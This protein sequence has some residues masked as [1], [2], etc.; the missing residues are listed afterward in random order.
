MNTKLGIPESLARARDTIHDRL[1]FLMTLRLGGNVK[2]TADEL[3]GAEAK[4]LR[5]HPDGSITVNTESGKVYKSRFDVTSETV[6][7]LLVEVGGGSPYEH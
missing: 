5:A 7:I 2:F 1:I 3:L 4:Q 6:S